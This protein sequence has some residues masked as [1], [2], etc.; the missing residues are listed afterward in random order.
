MPQI[1][2]PQVFD[3]RFNAGPV[4]RRRDGVWV[5][6]QY[7]RVDSGERVNQCGGSVRHGDHFCAR[8][9]SHC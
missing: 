5:V 6:W 4:K 1:M 3:A 2:E 7:A 8:G 9:L